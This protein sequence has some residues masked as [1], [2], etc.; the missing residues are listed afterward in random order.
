M[1]ANEFVGEREGSVGEWFIPE[2]LKTSV[3]K[4]TVGSN[5]AAS[6]RISRHLIKGCLLF[7]AEKTEPSQLLSG[8]LMSNC[9][10][11]Y[12]P[13]VMPVLFLNMRVK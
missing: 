9:P 4:G 1:P 10:R 6:A 5:P 13:G 2:V 8:R 11:M 3:L 7:L 12:S